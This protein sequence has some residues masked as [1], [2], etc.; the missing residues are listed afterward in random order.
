M[1]TQIL[2]NSSS[3]YSKNPSV[4]KASLFDWD[5]ETGFLGL[6]YKFRLLFNSSSENFKNPSIY[7]A[8]LFDW[9][10]ENQF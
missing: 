5:S 1:K 6:F 8:S 4:Y 3:E 10:S 7:K 9:D 2:F